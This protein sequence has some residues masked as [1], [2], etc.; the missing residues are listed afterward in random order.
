MLLLLFVM[1]VLTARGKGEYSG[2]PFAPRAPFLFVMLCNNIIYV[3][4][5]ETGRKRR[6]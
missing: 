2:T 6:T 5:I 3:A 4:I 1:C